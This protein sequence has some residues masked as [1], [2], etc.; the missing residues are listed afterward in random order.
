MGSTAAKRSEAGICRTSVERKLNARTDA[1]SARH[2]FFGSLCLRMKPVP[3]A[4]RIMANPMGGGS[5]KPHLVN[6]S[7]RRYFRRC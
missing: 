6:R 2:P 4:V 1:A 7:R 5:V 3:G